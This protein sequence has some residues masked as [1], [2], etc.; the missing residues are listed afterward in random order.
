[1]YRFKIKQIKL[2]TSGL[3]HLEALEEEKWM[4]RTVPE[5]RVRNLELNR[6]NVTIKVRH[7]VLLYYNTKPSTDPWEEL[8][9]IKTKYRNC[10]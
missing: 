1:M 5:Y 10:Q 8:S 7:S 2:K 3:F 9:Q 6:L 4:K